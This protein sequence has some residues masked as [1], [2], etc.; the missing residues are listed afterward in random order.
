CEFGPVWPFEG[1][2]EHDV[3][4]HAD[5][6]A[7]TLTMHTTAPRMPA[8]CGWHPWWQR[9]LRRGS[10]ATIDLPGAR[11]HRRDDEQIAV[12]ELVDPPPRPWDDCFTGL[13]GP[14]V[15]R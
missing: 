14:A 8:T 6:L 3:E 9:R 10:P 4:L 1:W 7:L 15:V 2:I 5:R 13:S 12:P 11:M